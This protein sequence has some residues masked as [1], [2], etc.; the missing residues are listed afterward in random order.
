MF[1]YKCTFQFES[2]W[3]YYYLGY[4]KYDNIEYRQLSQNIA[5]MST[6]DIKKWSMTEK[7]ISQ[8]RP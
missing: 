2:V 1:T 4:L 7:K 3:N 5:L 6:Q 8:I